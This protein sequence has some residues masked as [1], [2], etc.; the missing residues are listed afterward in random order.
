MVS[1]IGLRDCKTSTQA[2]VF[3]KVSVVN[4]GIILIHL[5]L[6]VTWPF[7][8]IEFTILFCCCSIYLVF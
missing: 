5:T 4:S 6:Y 8:L 2:I 3:F 7:P 1:F